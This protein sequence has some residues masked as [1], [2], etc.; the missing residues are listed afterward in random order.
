MHKNALLVQD[1]DGDG[2]IILRNLKKLNKFLFSKKMED[3]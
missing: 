3:H 1:I 2:V